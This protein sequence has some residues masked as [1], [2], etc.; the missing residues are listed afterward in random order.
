MRLELSVFLSRFLQFAPEK[1]LI[2]LQRDLSK[3]RLPLKDL[4]AQ[5]P[6]LLSSKT[7]RLCLEMCVSARDL[8]SEVLGAHD[9]SW[10][11]YLATKLLAA[12]Q[13]LQVPSLQHAL[14][15]DV[16]EALTY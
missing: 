2:D 3:N 5:Y 4:L 7:N 1:E 13:A 15:R 12:W 16:I 8:V 10:E 6:N 11:H 14:A 9:L